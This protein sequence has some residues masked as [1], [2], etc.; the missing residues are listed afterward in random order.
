[1][2]PPHR[3]ARPGPMTPKPAPAFARAPLWIAVLVAAVAGC[4][5]SP[6]AHPSTAGAPGNRGAPVGVI[7]IGHSGLTG[8]NSDPARPGQPAPENSW[9]TGTSPEVNSIY[10]R[11]VARHPQDRGHVANAAVGGT[12]VE[13]LP[14]Q[15]RIALGSV[16]NPEL[17]IVQTIDNDIRC[18]GTDADNTRSFGRALQQALE[19]I[20][21]ASP[22][23]R[24]LLA[25]QLGRP[26]T[27]F[28]SQL[29]AEHPDAK[30]SLTGSGICDFYDEHGK[31]R[32]RGFAELARIVE[33]YEA[34]Q[35]RVCAAVSSCSTDHGT[36]ARYADT[37]ENFSD[38]WNHLSVAGQAAEAELMWPAVAEIFGLG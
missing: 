3:D 18:D 36:R 6:A 14:S 38:D 30:D 9:A 10:Q 12:T 4:T 28:V 11:L 19:G 27:V 1:M 34:E 15:A 23:S 29:V 5:G 22:R 32:T 13:A 2:T 21:A 37:V 17:V 25:G 24:I 26:S 31:L 16:P 8:E 33:G 35:A 7:A 20:H